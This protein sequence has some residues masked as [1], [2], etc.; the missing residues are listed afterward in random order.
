[1]YYG[2]LKD[3]GRLATPAEGVLIAML[4]E[5]GGELVVIELLLEAG[6]VVLQVQ[7]CLVLVI[8]GVPVHVLEFVLHMDQLSLQL[9]DLDGVQFS[10]MV[11]LSFIGVKLLGDL[12]EPSPQGLVLCLKVLNEGL[13]PAALLLLEGEKLGIND[14]RS[15][16]GPSNGGPIQL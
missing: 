11:P 12:G 13:E 5:Y 7:D 14:V 4:L 10:D 2:F 15:T 8:Q 16:D 9:V 6:D 3:H 1:M